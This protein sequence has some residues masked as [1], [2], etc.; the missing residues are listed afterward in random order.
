ML[1]LKHPMG[2]AQIQGGVQQVWKKGNLKVED[3]YDKN[4]DY[5]TK[6]KFYK[7]ISQHFFFKLQ[8]KKQ[9]HTCDQKQ[10]VFET[11]T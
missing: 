6:K 7:E 11:N 1:L 2:G 5:S 3:G 10:S 4:K 9:L 8:L